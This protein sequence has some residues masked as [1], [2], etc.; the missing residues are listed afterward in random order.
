MTQ[1]STVGLHHEIE[2]RED[3]PVLVTEAMIGHPEAGR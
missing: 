3:A 2:G 1:V